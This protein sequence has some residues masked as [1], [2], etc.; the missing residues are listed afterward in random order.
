MK[1]K[2]CE[3]DSLMETLRSEKSAI[4][5]QTVVLRNRVTRMSNEKAAAQTNTEDVCRLLKRIKELETQL[6][7]FHTAEK[8]TADESQQ[9]N[10]YSGRWNFVLINLMP[11][12]S[13]KEF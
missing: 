1:N 11:R 12:I 8:P 5:Q 6:A 4:S 9:V 13:A 7:V 3:R 2:L 10:I